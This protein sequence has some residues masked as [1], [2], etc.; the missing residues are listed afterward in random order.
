MLSVFCLFSLQKGLTMNASDFAAAVRSG[1]PVFGMVVVSTA[2]QWPMFV[3]RVNPDFILL[4]NEHIAYDRETM[5]SLC[6]TYSALGIAPMVRVPSADPLL[7]QMMFDGGAAGVV[8]PYIETVEQLKALA[9]ATKFGPVKGVKLQHILDGGE[10]E[11]DLAAYLKARNGTRLLGTMIETQTALDALEDLLA[12]GY[13]DFVLVGPNDLSCSLGIPD[14]LTHPR[15]Q[16]AVQQIVSTARAYNVGVGM[17]TRDVDEEIRLIQSGATV[18]LHSSDASAFVVG[19][20]ADLDVLRR[21]AAENQP[22][23]S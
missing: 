14:Q 21:A 2:A 16:A 8:A 1:Q 10:I 6:L 17:M 11:P 19:M 12:T 13:L 23:H 22:A 7:V 18:I 20:S 15:F 9:G 4:E 5:A 3:R